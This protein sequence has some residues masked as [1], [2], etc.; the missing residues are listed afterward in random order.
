MAREFAHDRTAGARA[1]ARG[2]RRIGSRRDDGTLCTAQGFLGI[3]LPERYGG[4]GLTAISMRS[5][6]SEVCQRFRRRSRSHFRVGSFGPILAIAHFAPG[7]RQATHPR[8][9]PASE[10]SR[11]RCRTRRPVPRVDRFAHPRHGGVATRCTLSGQKRWCSGAGHAPTAISCIP[12]CP[13]SREPKGSERCYVEKDTPGFSFGKREH[14][15]G[16]RG[17]CSA[18]MCYDNSA[19]PGGGTSWCP[20]AEAFAS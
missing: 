7:L 14:S 4:H 11:C 3:N 12:A 2:R 8:S 1:A 20:R 18:D 9:L 5:S 13:T 17:I 10:S 15:M 19:R 6:F 16:F